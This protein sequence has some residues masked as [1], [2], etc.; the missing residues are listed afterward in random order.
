MRAYMGLTHALY[1]MT[2]LWRSHPSAFDPS[3]VAPAPR[4]VCGRSA[5]DCLDALQCAP[6]NMLVVRWFDL[7]QVQEAQQDILGMVGSQFLHAVDATEAPL[8][9][10]ICH[11]SKSVFCFVGSNHTAHKLQQHTSP[12]TNSKVATLCGCQQWQN[13][14]SI[15][16][17]ARHVDL[18]MFGFPVPG[19]CEWAGDG[20]P[21]PVSR[22][23][24]I[25]TLHASAFCMS[26]VS[27]DSRQAERFGSVGQLLMRTCTGAQRLL[28]HSSMAFA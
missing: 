9:T 17:V 15:R 19:A 1:C 3:H 23:F 12:M 11:L 24:W 21:R 16:L 26:M 27:I 28:M 14:L 25:F 13:S 22:S 7:A 4:E 6:L 10:C 2:G 8:H 20:A 5:P 18:F